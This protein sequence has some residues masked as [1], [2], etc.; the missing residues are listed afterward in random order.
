MKHPTRLTDEDFKIVKGGYLTSRKIAI[1]TNIF[2][3]YIKHEF[4][5]L[6]KNGM[7]FIEKN[8]F[9][10][11]ATCAIDTPDLMR[12]SLVHD[13]LYQALRE[14]L[15]FISEIKWTKKRHD[16]L[17]VKADDCLIMICNEDGMWRI[18]QWLVKRALRLANGLF[19]MPDVEYIIVVYQELQDKLNN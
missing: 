18:R 7:L 9:W 15:F 3:H 1:Q 14:L 16:E 12:G 11:G 6:N 17:R 10:D 8:Y 19:A 5:E 13:V 2:G 4:F